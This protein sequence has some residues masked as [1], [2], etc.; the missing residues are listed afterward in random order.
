MKGSVQWSVM[1]L[2][3]LSSGIKTQGLEIQLK[4]LTIQPPRCFYFSRKTY[5]YVVGAH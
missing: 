4:T 2:N 1:Q 5:M 3:S